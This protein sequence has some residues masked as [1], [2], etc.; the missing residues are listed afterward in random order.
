[1]SL[2]LHSYIT[3]LKA[4]WIYRS[5]A[6]IVQYVTVNKSHDINIYTHRNEMFVMRVCSVV[7]ELIVRSLNVND[8]IRAAFWLVQPRPELGNSRAIQRRLHSWQTPFSTHPSCLPNLDIHYKVCRWM[9]PILLGHS[10]FRPSLSVSLS[11]HPLLPFPSFNP[12]FLL[13]DLFVHSVVWMSF[14]CSFSPTVDWKMLS[15]SVTKEAVH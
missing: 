8:M 1:M 6:L 14:S 4:N 5:F 7:V 10:F 3:P 12:H 11:L 13:C 15:S 2:Q 9:Q